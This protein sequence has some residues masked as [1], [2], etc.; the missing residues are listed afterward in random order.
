MRFLSMVMDSGSARARDQRVS[1]AVIEAVA[2]EEGVDPVDLREPLF[3]AIDPNALET[4][5][6]NG[7]GRVTFEYHGYEVTVDSDRNVDV[8]AANDT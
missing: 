7:A 1:T 3:D 8:T 6:R 5:F 4:L 2:S